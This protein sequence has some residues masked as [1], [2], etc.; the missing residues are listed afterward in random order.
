MLIQRQ[1]QAFYMVYHAA[2]WIFLCICLEPLREE[3]RALGHAG[4]YHR[5][6]VAARG[7]KHMLKSVGE[8]DVVGVDECEIAAPCGGY[9]G[10]TGRAGAG[11]R[12]PDQAQARVGF[13]ETGDNS[14]SAVG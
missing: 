1:I 6:V 9:G 8:E 5:S 13:C 7:G 3:A 4:D 10:V 14:G 11:V 12:L 2:G